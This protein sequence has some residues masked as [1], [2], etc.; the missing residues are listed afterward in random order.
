MAIEKKGLFKNSLKFYPFRE[1]AEPI[2][3]EAINGAKDDDVY[4]FI[5]HLKSGEEIKFLDY[6]ASASESFN[7]ANFMNDVIFDSPDKIQFK[8]S[9]FNEMST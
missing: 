4:E 7:A 6:A 2:C 8:S 9:A 3:A 1:I 5:M